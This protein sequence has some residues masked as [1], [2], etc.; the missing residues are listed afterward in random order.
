MDSTGYKILL[1][2]HILAV[3][4]AF[5]GNFV[6][7]MLARAG[8][9]ADETFAKVSLYIQLPA[10]IVVFVA[11][12]GLIGMSDEAWKFSQTW[13]SLAFLVTILAAVLQYLVS[14]AWKNGNP[15]SVPGLTG[16]LHLLLLIAVYLMIFKPG[17]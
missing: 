9:V 8:N 17:L 2:I 3:I 7:P 16:G 4:V 11:G 14:R 15:K 10:I 12:M 5:G 1:L 6:Q 13:V